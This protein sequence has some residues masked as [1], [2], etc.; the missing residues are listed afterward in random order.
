VLVE[1]EHPDSTSLYPPPISG[2]RT[3]GLNLVKTTQARGRIEAYGIE[4]RDSALN[5][6]EK[7]M[8]GKTEK[9]AKFGSA[10]D[11]AVTSSHFL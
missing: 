5:G 4:R 2:R 3:R 10:P 7:G 8:S 9:G 1:S 6:V 11:S